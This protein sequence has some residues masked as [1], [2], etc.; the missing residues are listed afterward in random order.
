M[1]LHRLVL[2][3]VRA[4]V[5]QRASDGI[6]LLDWGLLE[7]RCLPVLTGL[8]LAALHAFVFPGHLQHWIGDTP[9]QWRF[10]HAAE[11]AR[12]TLS[13]IAA[14]HHGAAL[15]LY[16]LTASRPLSVDRHVGN[17]ELGNALSAARVARQHPF[18]Q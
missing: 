6:L 17:V 1:D 9:T 11:T 15:R 7:Q 2:H 5:Q 10:Y 4:I 16:I 18:P 13:C 14:E 8:I 3:R 12:Q